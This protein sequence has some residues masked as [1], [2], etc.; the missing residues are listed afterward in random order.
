MTRNLKNTAIFVT[1]AIALSVLMHYAT[2]YIP[3]YKVG[4]CFYDRPNFTMVQITEVSLTEYSYEGQTVVFPVRGKMSI[5]DF[6]RLNI[7]HVDCETGK[8]LDEKA[9]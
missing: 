4:D 8:N 9:N 3:K 7:D 1:A 2:S 5:R 6:Q